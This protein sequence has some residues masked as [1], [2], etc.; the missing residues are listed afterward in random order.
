MVLVGEEPV[1]V[2]ETNLGLCS[3]P[4]WV[5]LTSAL[6]QSGL[7][8]HLSCRFFQIFLSGSF[9]PLALQLVLAGIIHVFC[10]FTI[11]TIPPITVCNACFEDDGFMFFFQIRGN[12]FKSPSV[13]HRHSF[14]AT[15]FP[16][17][18]A[19]A[20]GWEGKDSD[21]LSLDCIFGR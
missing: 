21:K 19:D 3:M 11:F 4:K 14:T 2:K 20:E 12:L 17:N 5:M 9:G 18:L 8:F 10:Y 16:Q 1:I 13:V 6:H 15:T 7:W